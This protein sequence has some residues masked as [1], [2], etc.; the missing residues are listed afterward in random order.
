M[1]NNKQRSKSETV[2]ACIELGGTFISVG[3]VRKTYTNGSVS[4]A[5]LIGAKKT[6]ETKDPESSLKEISEYLKTLNFE[7]LGIASFGPICLNREDA[8]YGSITTAPKL[9]W[10]NFP[11]VS[12]VRERLGFRGRI[13]FDTDVNAAAL[14]EYQLGRHGVRNSLI[15]ITVGTGVGIGLIINGQPVHG[16]MHPEGGHMLIPLHEKE[17]NFRGNCVF[18]GACLEGLTSNWAIAKRFGYTD[19]EKLKEIP[20]EDPVWD[21]VAYYLAVFCENLAYA[22]SPEVIIL[23]GGVLNRKILYPKIH[24]LLPQIFNNYL[25]LYKTTPEK[26]VKPPA[27]G[28]KVGVI[29]ASVI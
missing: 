9:K 8:D 18:H 17:K 7:E 21:Y 19:V 24:Q 6:F 3:L 22:T 28:D 16:L 1:G 20:D 11:L 29:G 25:V 2:C 27:L 4:D 15:Y 10:Q 5:E 13:G 12:S 23:G 14:A 26:F